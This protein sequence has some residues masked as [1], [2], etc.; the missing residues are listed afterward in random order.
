MALLDG[1]LE[2]CDVVSMAGI[3]AL[4]EDVL[5]LHLPENWPDQVCRHVPVVW[6]S[7]VSPAYMHT[8]LLRRNVQKGHVQGRHIRLR[9]AQECSVV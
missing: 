7:I 1:T 3:G 2:G 9:N 5:R 8:D 6:T 4:D